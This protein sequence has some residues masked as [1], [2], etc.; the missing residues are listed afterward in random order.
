MSRLNDF[1]MM[2]MMVTKVRTGFEVVQLHSCDEDLLAVLHACALRRII[3][4]EKAGNKP[5]HTEPAPP[6]TSSAAQSRG[7]VEGRLIKRI[8]ERAPRH[9][10]W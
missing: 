2:M 10:H 8:A 5:T 6:A 3:I 9:H 1:R 7:E 4:A